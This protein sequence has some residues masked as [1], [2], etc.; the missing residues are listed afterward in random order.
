MKRIVLGILM[1]AALAAQQKEERTTKL[2]I[3]K[4]V[5]PDRLAGIVSQFGAQVITNGQMKAMTL[6]GFPSQIAAAEAALA[7]L[8]VPAKT[9]ELVVHF[10]IGSDQPNL[11]GSAV[12]ADVRDVITQ[13]KNTFTF[14]DYRMLDTLTVRTRAGSSADTTGI[15]G[16]GSNPRLSSFSVRNV[17]IGDDGTIRIDRM[18]AGLRIP[19]GTRTTETKT[20]PRTSVEYLN[21]GIDQDVDVKEGQKVVVGRSSLEGPDKALFLILTAR[22]L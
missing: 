2:V 1:A 11:A 8:D 7:R 6:S 9:V 19:T 17:T 5:D 13:L 20:G 15:L 12:P 10:V 14:K 3:L 16:S 22:V 4:Y 21:T 18:H